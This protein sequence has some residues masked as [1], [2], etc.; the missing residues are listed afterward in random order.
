MTTD[1]LI[2]LGVVI[3]L[4]D[5]FTA[6]AQGVI[7]KLDELERQ[8]EGS[9]AAVTRS[10]REMKTGFALFVAGSAALYG[11]NAATNH[12]AQFSSAIARVTTVS[13]EA[14][15]STEQLRQTTLGLNA[16][17]SGGAA[18]QADALYEAISS[19]FS[20]TAQAVEVLTVANKLAIGGVTDVD[21]ATK[22][23]SAVMLAYADQGVKAAHAS[24]LFFIAAAAGK[25]TIKELSSDLG[26]VVSVAAATGISLEELLAGVATATTRGM[27]TS[28]AVAGITGI[29]ANISRPTK[30]A[31]AEAHRLGIEFDTT[32][33]RAVGF[34]QFL[35]DIIQSPK[36]A[37]TSLEHLFHSL[38][39]K[40]TVMAIAAGNGQKFNDVMAQMGKSGG[41]TDVAF[42]KIAG[43]SEYQGKLLAAQ[44]DNAAI[45]IGSALEPIKAAIVGALASL[46]AAFNRLPQPVITLV[47]R[48]IAFAAAGAVVMGVVLLIKGVLILLPVAIHAVAVALGTIVI[49]LAPLL[50][51]IAAISG[52]IAGL[53]Y[54]WTRDLGGIRSTLTDWY[55]AASDVVAGIVALFTSSEGG[56]G[57]IPAALHERLVKRGLWPVV[58]QVY[59]VG[60]RILDVF[61]GVGDAVGGISSL[62][63]RYLAPFIGAWQ[64]LGLAVQVV[65]V[66]FGILVDSWNATVGAL[67]QLVFGTDAA[68]IGA[69]GLGEAIGFVLGVGWKLLYWGSGLWVIIEPLLMIS[70]YFKQIEMW[71]YR[72]QRAWQS[73]MGN[74][75]SLVDSKIADLQRAIDS[76]AGQPKRSAVGWA[77][78]EMSGAGGVGVVP[79]DSTATPSE[80]SAAR[81]VPWLGG[82]GMAPVGAPAAFGQTSRSTTINVNLSGRQI[83]QAVVDE[84][85]E[86]QVRTFGAAG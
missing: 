49:G 13:D 62:A 60:E 5:A 68:T 44:L 46:V 21:T 23:L 9:A 36:F 58:Q 53:Y 30:E 59:I 63:A 48:L 19:G 17:F 61:R 43:T 84:D 66:L 79:P 34:Q 42:Q 40:N 14:Q 10:L 75:T 83:H 52:A 82:G 3:S 11:L 24:D 16:Q 26:Q 81:G 70:D 22:G 71:I 78:D 80:R 35:Q 57:Q 73:F 8:A 54:V 74:D 50:P 31:R 65:G 7:R 28:S 37:A 67:V 86:A 39:G 2:G 47:T 6:T 41:A 20:N 29:I 69:R 18:K 56:I 72:A 12:A 1:D 4:K 15:M 85:N 38:E 77:V 32:R 27:A 55:E 51:I 76:T 45:Q 64:A 33:L 25:T